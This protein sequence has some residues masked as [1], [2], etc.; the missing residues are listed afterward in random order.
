MLCNAST[1]LI[2]T[3]LVWVVAAPSLAVFTVLVF[4]TMAWE[5]IGDF[6]RKR[7]LLASRHK[8]TKGR[9]RR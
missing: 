9:K 1:V 5:Q 7:G 8:R 2:Q 3:S 6:M 4:T